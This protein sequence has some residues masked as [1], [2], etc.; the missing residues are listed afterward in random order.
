MA[1]LI[2][3]MLLLLTTSYKTASAD[4]VKTPKTGQN[5]CYDV[6]GNVISCTGT[7]Q[8]G[9]TQ[10]GL[11]W[12]APRFTDNLNGTVTDNL[13][14]LIWLKNGGCLDIQP[15]A[16]SDWPT[17]LIAAGTLHSGQCGLSDGSV[18]GDWRLPNASEQVSLVD[19]S[20]AYPSLPAGNPFQVTSRD[21][22]W[23]ST[24]Y[25]LYSGN[26]EA[27]NIG[28]G[29]LR[30]DVKTQ[31]KLV[32]PVKGTSTSL[33]KTGQN[34]CWDATG[35]AIAC[36][37]TGQDGDKQAG[38][39]WPVPRFVDSG[40][41]TMVD[42]I[43]HL[44]WLKDANCFGNQ[45]SQDN[46]LSEARNLAAGAC[47]LTDGSVQGDWR[48]PNR[49]EMRSMVSYEPTNGGSWLNS[50]GFINTDYCYYWT[51]DSYPF[52][53]DRS[54]FPS[55]ADASLGDKWMVNTNGSAW[56]SSWVSSHVPPFCQYVHPVRGPYDAV[57][58][59][60]NGGT[61]STTP[62]TNLCSAGTASTVTGTGPWNWTCSA[63]QAN[64][65]EVSCSANVTAALPPTVSVTAP[66]SGATYTAPASVTVTAAAAPGTGASV[67]QV[68]FYSGTTWLAT[69]TAPPYSYTWNYATAGTYALTAKVTD[70]AGG[71][72]TSSAVSIVIDPAPV[73]PAVMVIAPSSGKNYTAPASVTII[74]SATPGTEASVKQVE[75][76]NG[77][78]LLGSSTASPYS[79]TWTNIASGNYSLTAKV[80][81]TLGATAS[82]NAVTIAVKDPP[83]VVITAP[84]NGAT[85]IAPATVKVQAT[86]TSGTG[87]SVKQVDFYIGS[88]LLGT[89]TFSPYSY[90][91]TNVAP[92]S[93]SLT[94]KVTNTLGEIAS[95]STIAI[96]VNA[97]PT[98][99]LTTPLNG[100][101]YTAPCTV[102]MTAAATPGT[103]AAVKQVDFYN[104]ATLLGSSTASPYSYNW[105]DPQPGSYTVTA[106][107]TD[108]LG[109]SATSSAA[110]ITVKAPPTITVTT[111]VNGTVYT[112]P[113]TIAIT[114]AVTAGT[115][116]A[117]RKVDFYDGNTL[118]G[119]STASPYGYT[120]SAVPAGTYSLTA[121]VT[122]SLG[123]TATTQFGI[124]VIRMTTPIMGPR[125]R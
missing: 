90:T 14:G 2:L 16:G 80:I 123:A 89:S 110:G 81:D 64:S 30:A 29:S 74:A 28:N 42:M 99:T 117:V 100:A 116:A 48:L 44:V 57:C 101:T 91:W 55:G 76:Y 50:Q 58:G 34:T 62:S 125:R 20:K 77:A 106:K 67:K 63:T 5:L 11:P 12:P 97:P 18:P 73:P 75:F 43:T 36:G 15:S 6:A 71:T 46:A 49:N 61:F 13:T 98:I 121:K 72:A 40:D 83:A 119:S 23:T 52:G 78:T 9:E 79:Y 113:A 45:T 69:S 56:L 54:W 66:S 114:V 68:D 65:I 94:A 93:Y 7:G 25:P 92:G 17:A 33:T 111:P 105:N 115:G 60:A 85:F 124:T 88:T 108:T 19:L 24:T 8:D 22:V 39:P 35:A 27:V 31:L 96:T 82:S 4:T 10:I 87:A 53:I 21:S 70:S 32:W 51:S 38:V 26:A 86:A 112:A 95:S 59:S 1:K 103:G 84:S 41:G 37:G 3:L 118:L 102:T 47:G 120:W 107:V 109:A 104:G 122:D